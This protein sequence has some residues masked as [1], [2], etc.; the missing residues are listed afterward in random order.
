M[1]DDNKID[2]EDLEV[3]TD[4]DD[5]ITMMRNFTVDEFRKA[6]SL[7]DDCEEVVVKKNSKKKVIL[8]VISV[9]LVLMLVGIGLYFLFFR[10]SSLNV[11][12]EDD[13][14]NNIVDNEVDDDIDNEDDEV[15]IN[16]Y[17]VT[18]SGKVEYKFDG[19]DKDSIYRVKCS[20]EDNCK[21]LYVDDEYVIV[22]DGDDGYILDYQKEKILIDKLEISDATLILGYDSS[23]QS[24][25]YGFLLKSSSSK[26][27]VYNILEDSLVIPISYDKIETVSAYMEDKVDG[28]Y[29]YLDILGVYD[30]GKYGMVNASRYKMVV[31]ISFDLGY[32]KYFDGIMYLFVSVDGDV[33]GYTTDGKKLLNGYT[34]DEM[35]DYSSLD[36]G[37]GIV[38]VSDE[39]FLVDSSGNTL[40]N[41]VTLGDDSVIVDSL[42]NITNKVIYVIVKS[43]NICTKYSYDM[44]IVEI[45]SEDVYCEV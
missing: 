25:K 2:T 22:R 18:L 41:F 13:T 34:F 11:D 10:E 6:K 31:P 36:G 4:I 1:N 15:Y 35:Y 30:D 39:V 14:L 9:V 32:R 45:I 21:G 3:N 17:K 23:I 33:S 24:S 20:D 37:Y 44:D 12:D 38:K 28:V 43:D 16:I 26:Y 8:I 40:I 29:S 19:D 5:N 7:L 27:G 42:L